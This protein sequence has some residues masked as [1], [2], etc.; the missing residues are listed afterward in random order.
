MSAEEAIDSDLVLSEETVKALKEFYAENSLRLTSDGTDYR[1]GHIEEDWVSIIYSL[2]IAWNWFNCFDQQLSQFWYTEETANQLSDQ[3][4]K[5]LDINTEVTQ[6]TTKS[7]ACISCPTLF[8]SL[9]KTLSKR[10]NVSIDLVLLEFDKRFEAKYPNHFVYYDYNQPIDDTLR[11]RFKESSVEAVVADPP[12]LSEECLKKMSETIK[13][14]AKD[15]I[16]VCTGVVMQTLVEKCLDLKVWDH[17]EPKHNRKLGNEFRCFA[18]FPFIW[19]VL[20][21]SCFPMTLFN[22]LH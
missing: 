18:N 3:I 4:L 16:M 12:F 13:Y 21:Q 17:F 11:Q 19:F 14:L 15:K 8:D 20:F 22:K 6:T 2:L 5:A 10:S 9:L 1:N 7:I